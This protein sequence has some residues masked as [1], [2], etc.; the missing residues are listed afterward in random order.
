MR[1][2]ERT[3]ISEF[4]SASGK[5]EILFPI[6]VN[7]FQI[8]FSG[9]GYFVTFKDLSFSK[10]RVVLDKPDIRGKLGGVEVGYIAF[11]QDHELTLECYSYGREISTLNRDAGFERSKT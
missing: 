2:F 11:I 6:Q 3:I 5:N 8:E 4:I 1:E 9:A 10:S 7:S